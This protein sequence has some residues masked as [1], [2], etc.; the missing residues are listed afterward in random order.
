VTAGPA[1][2]A[3]SPLALLKIRDGRLLWLGR[4]VSDFGS[5]ATVGTLAVLLT[6]WTGSA[7]LVAANGLAQ[8]VPALLVLFLL[9]GIVDRHD[10]KKLM[11]ASD[12]VRAVLVLLLVF[13]SSSR[14]ALVF[15]LTAA[16]AAVQGFYDP[17]SNALLPLIAPRSMR[18]SANGLLQ[19]S[20]MTADLAGL[21]FGAALTGLALDHIWIAFTVDAGTFAISALCTSL[22]R[23]DGHAEDEVGNGNQVEP[24][25]S[26][27]SGLRVLRHSIVLARLVGGV[28][29]AQLGFGIVNVT[30]APLLLLVLHA[31][32]FWLGPSMGSLVLAAAVTGLLA[33]TISRHVRLGIL[34]V[35]G[36]GGTAGAIALLALAP[37]LATAVAA[38]AVLGIAQSL[39]GVGGATAM[40]N[41]TTNAHRGSVAASAAA[42]SQLAR[43]VGI[44]VV[45]AFGTTS[46]V[47]PLLLTA[48][49][50]VAAATTI[51]ARRRI[52][53]N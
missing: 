32:P 33:G 53:T 5:G 22:I 42:A 39:L 3:R 7:R 27:R 45:A 49:L 48:A 9:G 37:N 51:L 4:T 31:R 36:L 26:L 23:S 17:A 15:A 12:V 6:E 24:T 1:Q 38:L 52:D 13:S 46:Q 8:A 50:I 19:S 35:T 10:R 11:V 2:T 30:L 40:Q 14:V 25:R 41:L 29:V 18:A 34:I 28:S 21:S 44:L 47:R 43:L 16:Q 20:A